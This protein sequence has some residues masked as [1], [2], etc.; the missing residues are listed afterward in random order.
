MTAL[1]ERR[2]ANL[3][4]EVSPLLRRLLRGGGQKDQQDYQKSGL[5]MKQ[6]IRSQLGRR[7]GG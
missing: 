4:I 5:G 3:L 1:L 6:I 2:K 7:M